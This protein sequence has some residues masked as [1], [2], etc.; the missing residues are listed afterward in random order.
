MN[1][2]WKRYQLQKRF[3]AQYLEKSLAAMMSNLSIS[4]TQ[5]NIK[6]IYGC[7]LHIMQMLAKYL[8]SLEFG[9]KYVYQSL[10]RVLSICFDSTAI[11][12]TTL[13]NKLAFNRAAADKNNLIRDYVNKLP[14]FIFFHR[15]LTI[16]QP[17]IHR[18]QFFLY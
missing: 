7:Q 8:K 12:S 9:T 10:P 18:Y 3:N 6:E 4:S 2:P 1:R 15:F 11:N 16:N 13:I 17:I 14:A 5:E